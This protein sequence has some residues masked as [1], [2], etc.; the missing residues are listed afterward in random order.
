ME[1]AIMAKKTVPQ[2]NPNPEPKEARYE[3][4]LTERQLD[5]LG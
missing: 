2:P 5:I 1:A 4:G 3:Y